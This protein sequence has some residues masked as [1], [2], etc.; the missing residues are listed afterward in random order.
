MIGV[1]EDKT[2]KLPVLLC[3]KSTIGREVG[4]EGEV[5][6]KEFRFGDGRVEKIV[7][8]GAGAELID[9]AELTFEI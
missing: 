1:S 8:E 2:D 6:P 3:E 7:N 5:L 4:F 9:G